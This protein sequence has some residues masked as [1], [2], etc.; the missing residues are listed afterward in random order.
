MLTLLCRWE[1]RLFYRNS[2]LT[3]N[4]EGY[5]AMCQSR[6]EEPSSWEHTGNYAA[7]STTS[8]KG[9]GNWNEKLPFTSKE[10]DSSSSGMLLGFPGT[11]PK[12]PPCHTALEI[13][14]TWAF[15]FRGSPFLSFTPLKPFTSPSGSKTRLYLFSYLRWSL[16]STQG[17]NHRLLRCLRTLE[18]WPGVA[19]APD[20]GLLDLILISLGDRAV[21]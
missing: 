3:Q 11:Y 8:R 13:R 20:E 21:T 12:W 10:T 19:S 6:V 5:T 16:E 17:A 18:P 7:M 9:N 14:C 2:Q 1:Q 4:W 15:C